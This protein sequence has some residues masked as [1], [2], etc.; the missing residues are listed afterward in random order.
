SG[1][2]VMSAQGDIFHNPNNKDYWGIRAGI[3]M[4]KVNADGGDY[5]IKP[6]VSVGVINNVPLVANLYIEPG[7]KFYYDSYSVYSGNFDWFIPGCDDTYTYTY[8]YSYH[9]FGFRIPVMAGYR[10]DFTNGLRV[11]LFTGPVFEMGLLAK[12][13]SKRSDGKTDTSDLYTDLGSMNRVDIKWGVGAGIAYKSYYLEASGAAGLLNLTDSDR[14]KE[15]I[16][17]I[18]VGYNF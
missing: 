5:G 3:E 17:T 1:I 10:F 4:T 12:E 13:R 11:N 14:Y 6:G 2:G 18:S 8:T 16:V 9:K 15:N 7:L